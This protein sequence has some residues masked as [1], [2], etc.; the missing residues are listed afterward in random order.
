MFDDRSTAKQ[1]LE[2]TSPYDAKRLGSKVTG[3][4]SG[5]LHNERYNL[6]YKGI[7][8]KFKQNPE[9]LFM[10]KAN[11]SKLVVEASTD[12]LWGMGIAL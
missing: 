5:R 2:S 11:G 8:E 1:I 4:D 7:R 10:L 6:C 3:V 12:H 9:L